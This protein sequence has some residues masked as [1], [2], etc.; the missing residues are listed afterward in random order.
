[1]PTATPDDIETA[2]S[3]LLGE[4]L[5]AAIRAADTEPAP[6]LVHTQDEDCTL[7]ASQECACGVSHAEQCRE[8]SGRGYHRV[9]CSEAER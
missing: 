8:C 7:D 5:L 1:M 2:L 6:A 4:E 3:L 9:A